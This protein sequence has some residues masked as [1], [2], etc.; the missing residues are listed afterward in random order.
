MGKKLILI[1]D[2]EQYSGDLQV[3][4]QIVGNDA[5]QG[6]AKSIQGSFEVVPEGLVLI[7]T[8][9]PITSRDTSQALIRRMITFKAERVFEERRPFISLLGL[10]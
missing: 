1:S 8:N 4:K 6:R 5:L 10:G 3:L 2:S 7:V 9:H